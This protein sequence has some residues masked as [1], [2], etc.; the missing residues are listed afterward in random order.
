MVHRV[1]HLK[2]KNLCTHAFFGEVS[3]RYETFNDI[4]SSGIC[5]TI[6][7]EVFKTQFM[8]DF[9]D[10]EAGDSCKYSY[11]ITLKKKNLQ[12]EWTSQ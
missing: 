1:H 7:F 6:N 11:A 5:S 8:E 2:P 4:V 3:S 12:I 9:I 10:S